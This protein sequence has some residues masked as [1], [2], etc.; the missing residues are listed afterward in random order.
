MA[1]LLPG[2]IKATFRLANWGAGYSGATWT[3]FGEG[4]SDAV[5][6]G[7]GGAIDYTCVQSAGPNQCPQQGAL[8]NHQCMLVELQGTGGTPIDFARDSAWRN[9]DFVNNSELER[10]AE[11][12]LVGLPSLGTP[13]RD[14]YVYVKTVNMPGPSD[15]EIK[16]PLDR[17]R[18]T[19]SMM[20][21]GPVRGG[22][23]PDP[24]P[25][26]PGGKPVDKPADKPAAEAKAGVA[27][28][29][30][31]AAVAPRAQVPRRAA[32]LPPSPGM[33]VHEALSEVWPTYEVHVYYETGETM[34]ADGTEHRRLSPLVP[35]GYF[36][37]HKGPLFGFVHDFDAIDGTLVEELA[38]NFYRL[39][40]P[41][42][43]KARVTTKIA[44][45]DRPEETKTE[46]AVHKHGC[47]CNAVGAA[48]GTRTGAL[49]L[50]GFGISLLA[51]RRGA[52]R[53]RSHCS[54]SS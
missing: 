28:A 31:A 19:L 48:G 40:I 30:A 11:I 6:G 5:A 34:T 39:S 23:A 54:Q 13:V 46:P 44:S 27:G 4:T 37:A 45:L 38:P 18:E 15:K 35:F 26:Q 49:L 20:G 47:H 51:A 2:A 53:R 14:I 41:D 32:P 9:M 33:S 1:N 22:R 24:G 52:R 17:M 8:Q 12:N 3:E 7:A 36:I 29:V 50:C 21:H 10:E 16:L 43:G 42:G 25:D